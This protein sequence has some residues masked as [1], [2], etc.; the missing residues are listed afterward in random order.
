M[1]LSLLCFYLTLIWCSAHYAYMHICI[2]R[3]FIYDNVAVIV[4][5]TSNYWLLNTEYIRWTFNSSIMRGNFL[6]R[7][8][9][10]NTLDHTWR[11]FFYECTIS[12]SNV[13][14]RMNYKLTM[15]PNLNANT[16]R[17]QMN[18]QQQRRCTLKCDNHINTLTHC[19]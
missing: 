12:E 4:I 14:K 18:K 7:H 17:N 13:I 19:L 8:N 6:V 15:Y 5:F 3:S 1:F 16:W 10:H 9:I 2:W 11:I